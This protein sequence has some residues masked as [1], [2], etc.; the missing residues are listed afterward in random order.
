M[1][2]DFLRGKACEVM[3]VKVILLLV[4]SISVLSCLQPTKQTIPEPIVVEPATVE[5]IDIVARQ[6]FISTLSPNYTAIVQP[7]VAGYLS[8]KLFKNGMPV[9]MGQTIFKIDNRRQRADMLAAKA[10]LESAKAQ[11]VEAA[12]N[13]N[14][15]VPLAAIDAISQA[16]LDQY[17]AQY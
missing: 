14:R 12:N 3:K 6:S 2:F 10:S 7:R 17:T 8:A 13:Y 15:A 16:Q 9:K 11:A 4:L 5:A 1:F